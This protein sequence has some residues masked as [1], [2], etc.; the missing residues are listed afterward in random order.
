MHQLESFFWGIIAALGALVVEIVVFVI[1]SAYINQNSMLAFSQLSII[2][3]YIILFACIEEFFKYIVIS[4]RIEMLSLEKSYLI[5]SFLV[6]LGFFGIELAFISMSAA[7]PTW[8]ILAEIAI[9]HIGTAG[10]IG[11]IVAIGN[12]RKFSTL[13]F[14]LPVAVFFHAIYN[15]LVIKREFWQNY[16]VFILLGLLIFINT[17]NFLRISRKP[18]QD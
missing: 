4:R 14:A 11:Y 8:K 9:L 6:G 15:L 10:L 7:L 3:Q 13:I 12:P 18:A 2:P 17:I 5:N 16:A 1:I